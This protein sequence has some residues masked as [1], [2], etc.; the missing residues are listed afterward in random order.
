MPSGAS[1]LTHHKNRVGRPVEKL[2]LV[3]AEDEEPRDRL[4][5]FNHDGRLLWVPVEALGHGLLAHL[6]EP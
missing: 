3:L 4:V 2:Q 5:P 6:A 1:P